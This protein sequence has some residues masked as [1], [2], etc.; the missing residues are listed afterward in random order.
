MTSVSF[1]ILE[2]VV[3]Y[4]VAERKKRLVLDVRTGAVIAPQPKL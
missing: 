2:N 3:K 4:I 1:S